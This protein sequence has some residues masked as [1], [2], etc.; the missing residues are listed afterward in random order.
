[1]S[2]TT[3]FAAVAAVLAIAAAPQVASAKHA[4][5]RHSTQWSLEQA[6]NHHTFRVPFDARASA[7]RDTHYRTLRGA[8]G[9]EGAYGASGG[10][11]P[12]EMNPDRV[13]PNQQGGLPESTPNGY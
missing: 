4:V 7:G 12:G 3:K 10:S 11:I 5:V 1:M 6:T 8:A 9:A 2:I 13:F